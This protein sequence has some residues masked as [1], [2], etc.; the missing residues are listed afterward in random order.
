ML[1]AA[2]DGSLSRVTSTLSPRTA[3]DLPP[4]EY[5]A[6]FSKSPYQLDTPFRIEAD[7]VSELELE[8]DA[9]LVITQIGR[10]LPSW[11]VLQVSD[12]SVV[13]RDA[14]ARADFLLAPGAY[15]IRA[16][17]D[18]DVQEKEISVSAGDRLTLSF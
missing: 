1:K 9:G 13:G 18:G 8:L 7:V 12:G 3:I 16:D 10:G 2:A 14:G 5:V 11:S 17:V 6:R 4:G 15:V